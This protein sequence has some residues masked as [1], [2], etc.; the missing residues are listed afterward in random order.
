MAHT[1][2]PAAAA[3]YLSE[4]LKKITNPY[5]RKGLHQPNQPVTTH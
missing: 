5:L 3:K 1:A 2:S 4:Q